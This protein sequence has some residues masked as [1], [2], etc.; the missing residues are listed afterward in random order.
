M[1]IVPAGTQDFS[2]E[3]MFKRNY[4]YMIIE[5]VYK[6]FGAEP[7]ETPMFELKNVLVAK[8]GD[9]NEKLIFELKNFVDEEANY[10]LRYDLT[11][12]LGRFLQTHGL[13]SI[14]RYQIG[15]VFRRDS[16]S[17]VQN[18]FREFTQCDVDFAG[19]CDN[20]VYDAQIIQII[21]TVLK[22]QH[23]RV[24]YSS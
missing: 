21:Q 13:T 23:S 3:Q 10:A 14:K 8:Y 22:T 18:R 20:M 4:V 24:Y 17:V 16:P 12:P 2:S 5:Q 15:K 1:S 6:D 11:V 7:M 9:E 19:P